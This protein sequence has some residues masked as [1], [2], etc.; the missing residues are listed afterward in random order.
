MVIIEIFSA[1]PSG[2]PTSWK[3]REEG[4]PSAKGRWFVFSGNPNDLNVSPWQIVEE[5]AQMGRDFF[6]S[7]TSDP[8]DPW[9]GTAGTEWH[10]NPKS[11]WKY[12]T[13]IPRPQLKVPESATIGFSNVTENSVMMFWNPQ[14][15]GDSPIT[16]Y[17]VLLKNEDTGQSIIDFTTDP[18]QQ[19]IQTNLFVQNLDSG[20]NYKGYVTVISDIG[21][22]LEQSNGFKTLGLIPVVTPPVIIPPVIIPPVIIPPADMTIIEKFEKGELGFISFDFKFWFQYDINSVKNG[23][24]NYQDF[25]N[26]YNN[27]VQREKIIDKTLVTPPVVIPPVVD[28]ITEFNVNVYQLDS[29]GNVF[30]D[31]NLGINAT[32]LLELESKYFVT[33]VGT[34]TPSDQEVKDFYNY[35]DV[36]TSVK[37]TMV[38]A[39]FLEF[40]IVNEYVEGKINFVSTASASKDPAWTNYWRDRI[41]Y[42]YFQVKDQAGNN[43]LIGNEPK[44]AIKVNDLKFL[45]DN[46]ETINYREY[47]GNIQAVTLE[48]YVWDITQEQSLVKDPRPF[49]YPK[50]LEVTV[51]DGLCPTGYHRGFNGKCIPDG[52]KEK[53]VG[54]S[55]LGKVMG[56]TALLGTLALL[57]SKRR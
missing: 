14:G 44:Q 27:L 19:I 23:S 10:N 55:L 8:A 53:D 16:S 17:H 43:I 36:D 25:L 41:I 3:Y 18:R 4:V 20:T 31:I 2:R 26:T 46:I 9:R 30:N 6:Q 24:V 28:L 39:R 42:A 51:D 47:I 49:S 5:Q 48:V 50:E 52:G 34:P 11:Y 29:N 56:V 54:S 22:S 45:L 37:P 38:E 1:I 35:I 57:G 32:K 12:D 33:S 40:K 7:I 13:S 15:A 21:N